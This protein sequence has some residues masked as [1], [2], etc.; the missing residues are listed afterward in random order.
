MGKCFLSSSS[1]ARA[2][3]QRTNWPVIPWLPG[4]FECFVVDRSL[5]R[6]GRQDL[7]DDEHFHGD[8]TPDSI[9]RF[10]LLLLNRRRTS[11]WS[12]RSGTLLASPRS[13]RQ[14]LRANHLP[15]CRLR[16][17]RE[18]FESARLH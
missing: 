6:I 10:G 7:V 16:T 3:F 18:S 11:F 1:F 12:W 5:V 14:S 9:L 15:K 2:S 17:V 8:L 13:R 4:P